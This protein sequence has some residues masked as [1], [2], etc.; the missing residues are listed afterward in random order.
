MGF[1]HCIFSWGAHLARIEVN[2]FTGELEVSDYLAVTEAG[3]V[4][5]PLCWRQQV[6][7]G[8]A[9]GL[10]YALMEDFEVEDGIPLTPDLSTYIVPTAMDVPRFYCPAVE[11]DEPTGPKGLKGLGELPLIGPL[12]AVGNA[13][14]HLSGHIL[15]R[16]PFTAERVLAALEKE[17]DMS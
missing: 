17:S 11:L 5:N 7:G 14:A 9:Q 3:R 16:S 2:C 10:G 15:T 6:E 8:V 12:P 4:I 1:P 13:L